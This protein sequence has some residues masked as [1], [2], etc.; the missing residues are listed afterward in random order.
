MEI[1][2][3]GYI[4]SFETRWARGTLW[5]FSV[6]GW[7]MCGTA[8]IMAAYW[9]LSNIVC[10]GARDSCLL[11]CDHPAVGPWMGFLSFWTAMALAGT[12]AV[13]SVFLLDEW[14]QPVA[15]LGAIKIK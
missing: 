3:E 9:M 5:A 6:V 8:W 10:T 1:D 4:A 12:W 15:R 11:P 14:H 13:V 2:G 7:A